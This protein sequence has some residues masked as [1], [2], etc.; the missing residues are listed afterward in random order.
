MLSSNPFTFKTLSI[1]DEIWQ[2]RIEIRSHMSTLNEAISA[3]GTPEEINAWIEKGIVLEAALLCLSGEKD[4]DY[5]ALATTA[6]PN[7]DNGWLATTARIV[8]DVER[9]V[10]ACDKTFL[11]SCAKSSENNLAL[12]PDELIITLMA[13]YLDNLVDVLS[14]TKTT[15]KYHGLFRN[16][17]NQPLILFRPM[18]KHAALGEWDV[19]KKIAIKYPRLLDCK[20][21][22]EH[23]HPGRYRYENRSVK[24][25]ALAN[26]EFKIFNELNELAG[27]PLSHEK[28]QEQFYEIFPDG[29]I[30][31]EY[32]CDLE[33][34]KLLVANVFDAI[35]RDE[36]I[37]GANL[38]SMSDDTRAAL[39]LLEDYLDPDKYNACQ[40]G[41]VFDEGIWLQALRHFEGNLNQIRNSWDK[42]FFW[43][44]R[45]EEKIA[46]HLSTGYLRPHCFGIGHIVEEKKLHGKGCLLSDGTSYFNRPDPNFLPGVHF[47]V[48]YYGGAA[49]TGAD[50]W[51]FMTR[52][53]LEKLC[54]A[55][56]RSGTNL[57]DNIRGQKTLQ[58]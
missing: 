26:Q 40:I 41:L 53:R 9:I 4:I 27:M 48:G 10:K 11:L 14:I 42:C 2:L 5:L 45:V 57:C 20:G 46:S 31:V 43:C 16:E 21:T 18:L 36:K 8:S 28:N 7:H 37:D 1:E 6:N 17:K 29:E 22:V 35:V 19:V 49:V 38:D 52:S 33:T 30:R 54:R 55:K 23:R 24:Q 34:V 15:R 32:N 39:K 58:H 44:V 47:F 3:G 25:I 51:R 13:C 12:L 50:L 56:T